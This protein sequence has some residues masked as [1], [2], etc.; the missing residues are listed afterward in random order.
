MPDISTSPERYSLAVISDDAELYPA[1]RKHLGSEFRITLASTEAEIKSTLE[2]PE[3]HAILFNLD[4][5]GNG[6]GDGLDVLEEIRKFRDDVVLA[7]FTRSVQRTIPLKASQ[8]G[9]DPASQAGAAPA[10]AP[11][12][13][14]VSAGSYTGG[15]PGGS[16]GQCVVARESGGQSQV[17]NATGHYGLYQFSASTW[18]AYGGNPIGH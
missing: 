11:G 2:L 16:F 3:L 17:M 4:C 9:A 15:T 13:A 12:T 8:A 7:V 18:A 6:P 1:V 10:I 5:I 14:A